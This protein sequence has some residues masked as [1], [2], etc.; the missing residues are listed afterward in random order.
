MQAYFDAE[1]NAVTAVHTERHVEHCKRCGALFEDLEELRTALRRHLP[2]VQTPPGLRARVMRALNQ[3]GIANAPQP[4]LIQRHWRVRPFWIGAA[5][6]LGTA[7]AAASL[8]L[9]LLASQRTT[10]MLDE[11][12]GSHSA[13]R[14][15]QADA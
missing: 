6:G 10:G 3:K 5:G 7:A 11:L 12:V 9:I 4:R 2:Y 15:E 13:I 8:A 14:I 1:V